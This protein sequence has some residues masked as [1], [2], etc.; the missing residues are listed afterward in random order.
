MQFDIADRI[1]NQLSAPGD[2]VFDPFG[3]LMTVPYRAIKLGR[4]GMGVE[5]SKPY[6]LDGLYY[7]Q[8]AAEK[9]AQP[10]LFDFLDAEE[11]VT[12]YSLEDAA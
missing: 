6:Y 12:D 7:C 10:S 9:K 2:I 3:G 1:I 11:E 5:L 8:Q 4:Y